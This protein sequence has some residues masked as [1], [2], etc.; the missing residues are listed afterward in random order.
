M[1]N[2]SGFSSLDYMQVHVYNSP[3]YITALNRLQSIS[4]RSYW[5]SYS[6]N[7]FWKWLSWVMCTNQRRLWLVAFSMVINAIIMSVITDM[8]LAG[9]FSELL[10]EGFLKQTFEKQASSKHC[11]V[12]NQL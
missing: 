4:A 2:E 9:I 3:H 1:S 5:M 7:N 12:L 6:F 10:F 8:I 11:H